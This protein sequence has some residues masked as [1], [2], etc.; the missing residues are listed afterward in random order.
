MGGGAIPT[1]GGIQ[2][3][4]KAAFADRYVVW[5]MSSW[6]PQGEYLA[7]RVTAASP[8]ELIRL[9]YEAAVQAV[10]RA[11]EGLRSGD[12]LRRGNSVSK[13]VEILS[14]LRVSLRREVNPEYCDTL[15][16]LYSYLQR[17]LIRAH[18]EKSE[19]LFQE[20][21]RLLR[22]LLDGWEGAM[23]K[24][25]SGK[26]ESGAAEPGNAA[27]PLSSSVP[28]SQEPAETKMLGRSWQF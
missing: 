7:H 14:E 11:L 8:L 26:E 19:D 1:N 22:T 2:K 6:N 17:Q 12:I 21:A 13:A 24:L 3:C 15:S 27:T 20:V 5:N 28:Y 9:L 25:K 16:G 4:F 18:A 10:D 23:E